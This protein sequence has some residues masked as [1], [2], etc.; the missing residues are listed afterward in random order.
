MTGRSITA[1]AVA[2]PCAIFS[3]ADTRPA[4]SPSPY[5]SSSSTTKR[6]DTALRPAGTC[7]SWATTGRSRSFSAFLDASMI[8]HSPASSLVADRTAAAPSN[9]ARRGPEATRRVLVVDDEEGIRRAIG[10]FLKTRGFDVV[11]AESGD[12]AL[13]QLG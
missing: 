13:S 7:V 9:T 4:S 5:R 3:S 12:E 1:I 10:R 6:G 11:T 8:D 2:R